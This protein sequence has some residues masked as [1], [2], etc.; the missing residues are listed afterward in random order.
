MLREFAAKVCLPNGSRPGTMKMTSSD[1]RLSTVVVS[2]A[3][4]AVIHVSTSS[5]IARSS[6]DI[7][8]SFACSR[9][10]GDLEDVDQLA[11]APAPQVVHAASCRFLC[12]AVDDFSL[13]LRRQLGGT[14]IV[15]PGLDRWANVLHEMRH[16]PVAAGHVKCQV[17]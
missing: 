13:R 4:L 14:E 5:R 7:T 17:R 9:F 16:A 2:P 12:N 1:I 10:A 6:G 15:H 8:E 11:V 3:R